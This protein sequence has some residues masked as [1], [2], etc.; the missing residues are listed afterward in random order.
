M[1]E[2]QLINADCFEVWKDLE[3][4]CMI[5]DPPYGLGKKLWGGA[6]SFGN[7]LFDKKNHLLKALEWDDFAPDLTTFL[8]KDCPKIIWGGNYFSLPPSRKWLVWD[9]GETISGRTFAEGELAWCS[10]DG[11]LRIKKFNPLSH[12]LKHGKVHLTQ[13]P[14]EIMNW[15][16][17]TMLKDHPN[18]KTVFDP[19][20]GSG[21]T[22][23]AALR[24]G[25]NFIGIEREPDI[26]KVA[27]NRFDTRQIDFMEIQNAV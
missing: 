14:C 19:F 4:D 11:N 20:M 1:S 12:T 13:K 15:C 25:L 16:I 24:Y 7:S 2:I 17:E 9:K 5:T 18:I 21:S 6:R 3:F 10:W 23:M 27:Q 8:V 26:F 22:G